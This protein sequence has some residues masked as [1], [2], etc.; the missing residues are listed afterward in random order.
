MTIIPEVRRILAEAGVALVFAPIMKRSG[1]RG[2]TQLLTPVKAMIIHGLKYRNVSQFWLILLHEIAHLVLHISNPGDVIADYDDQTSDP[3]EMEADEWARNT[4]IY[5]DKLIAFQARNPT[6]EVWQIEQFA[7]ELKV[8]TAIAAEVFNK[9][10]KAEVIQY[11]RLNRL[12]LFPGLS[13]E[14][15][16]FLWENN[17]LGIAG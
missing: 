9:R 17:S 8:H 1:F 16:A 2:C 12:G 15:A 5:S 14:E 13:E 11:A 6:P 3:R 4:L 7:R 10:A